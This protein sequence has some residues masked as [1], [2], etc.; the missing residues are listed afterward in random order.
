M[1][2]RKAK[3]LLLTYVMEEL[4]GNI[5]EKLKEHLTVCSDCADE[6]ESL[7]ETWNLLDVPE[8][9]DVP[10]HLAQEVGR[11]AAGLKSIVGA[12]GSKPQNQGRWFAVRLTPRLSAG[13]VGAGLAFA[14]CILALLLLKPFTRPETSV[15]AEEIKIGFYLTEHERVAQYVSFH[16]VSRTS[17]TPRWIPMNREDMFYYDGAERKG[18]GLFLR[19]RDGWR[20]LPEDEETRPKITESELITSSKAQDLMPFS[21]VAPEVLGG[22]YELGLVLRIRDRECVQL[23]YSDGAHTLSLFQQSVWTE[24]GIRRKDF[25]EYV[26]HKSKEGP[27]NAVLG[28]LTK[29]IAFNLVGEV[30]FSELVQLSE[31]IQEKIAVDSLQNFYEELYGK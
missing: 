20:S 15:Q 31:Q 27:R 6:L 26:L 2:C 24:N 18:S 21:I 17:S 5:E 12:R 3:K 16:A 13:L 7:K 29:E 9:I 1:R 23:V 4:K 22:N 30:G 14:C 28:W 19:S 8:E 25:Q 10:E 11:Q